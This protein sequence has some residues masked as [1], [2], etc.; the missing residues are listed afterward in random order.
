MPELAEPCSVQVDI[1][2]GG[3]PILCGRTDSHAHTWQLYGEIGLEYGPEPPLEFRA[4][5]RVLD[6]LSSFWWALW[7]RSHRVQISDLPPLP[8]RR[9]GKNQTWLATA[10]LWPED[11]EGSD[12]G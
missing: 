1:T 2:E 11:R 6:V 5:H 10:G 12:D 8:L 3:S 9:H 7:G 4:R